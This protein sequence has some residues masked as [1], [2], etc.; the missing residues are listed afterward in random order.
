MTTQQASYRTSSF[1]AP[2]LKVTTFLP[3]F[4]SSASPT[5][6][7][8]RVPLRC[9]HSPHHPQLATGSGA[10]HLHP[11]FS[12]SLRQKLSSATK[13]LIPRLAVIAHVIVLVDRG[14]ALARNSVAIFVKKLDQIPHYVTALC[15]G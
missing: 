10:V 7:H 3:Y 6:Q 11:G 13:A 14:P 4:S 8:A 1:R 15:Q 2:L 12:Q 5:C 9:R